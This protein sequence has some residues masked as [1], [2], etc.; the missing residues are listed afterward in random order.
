[1]DYKKLIK[2]RNLRLKILY[3][4]NWIPDKSMI[5]L[6]YRVKTGRRLNLKN[7]TRYTEK[8]QWYKLYHRN[9]LMAQCAD[10]YYV[11]EYVK[12]KKLGN[13]LNP[14]YGVFTSV[15]EINLKKLP[16]KFVLKRTNGAGGNDVII[17]KDKS[18]FDIDN[19][20]QT[21]KKWTEQKKN[22]GGREWIYYKLNPQIIIEKYIESEDD[23]LIDYKF[24]CF[25][26]EP[27]YLYV[28]NGRKLGESAKLG[29]FDMNFS[30]LPYFRKDE[31]KMLEAPNKPEN[32]AEM[33]NIVKKL[34]EDFPHVRVDLY[35]IK[36]KIIFGELT[37]F[38]GSGYQPFEPD[39]FDF[40]MGKNFKLPN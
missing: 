27:K 36:G 26:G 31:D 2:S 37:F 18:S 35:N 1:M 24:F 34:S 39:E 30:Q 40:I 6:Q 5:R 8:L 14:L 12:N 10:K 3:L 23:D 25:N 20:M 17:C 33:I 7:P 19:W 16:D 15:N 13:I 28:I 22:G 21:M 38:D 11:R 29:I 4:F 9:P 32:F